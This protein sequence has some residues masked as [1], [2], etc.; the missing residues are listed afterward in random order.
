MSIN[1]FSTVANGFLIRH[2]CQI[3]LENDEGLY[4]VPEGS[5]V[6]VSGANGFYLLTAE[7][8]IENISS[9]ILWEG[10]VQY[11]LA[12]MIEEIVYSSSGENLE[13]EATTETFQDEDLAVAKL[14]NNAAREI[15]EIGY[16][17]LSKSKIDFYHRPIEDKIPR[18]IAFGFP[19]RKTRR[20]ERASHVKSIPF[21]FLSIFHWKEAFNG[22][23]L[24]Q[25]THITVAYNIKKVASMV[26]GLFRKSIR[27]EGISGGG[28]WTFKRNE[29]QTNGPITFRL[30]GI[31][32]E[33]RRKEKVMVASKLSNLGQYLE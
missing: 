2:T 22:E 15:I 27:P 11:D 13:I 23:G 8:V 32:I 25:N 7:H 18:Y 4:P 1:K 24:D 9:S 31:L 30:V 17:F 29:K 19:V 3:F 14:K 28:L 21:S 6:F 20:R 16:S 33:Y 10:N 26:T 5:G 12:G